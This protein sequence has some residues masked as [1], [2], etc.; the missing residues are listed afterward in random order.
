MSNS[1]LMEAFVSGYVLPLQTKMGVREINKACFKLLPLKIILLIL[2]KEQNKQ[3]KKS[4]QLQTHLKK[5]IT[6]GLPWWHS[7]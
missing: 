3:N 4:Y 6:I 5:R 7:G 1:V 2:Y